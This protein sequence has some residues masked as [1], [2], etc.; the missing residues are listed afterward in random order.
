MD[1]LQGDSIILWTLS[2]GYALLQGDC[3]QGD[4]RTQKKD[5]L[6]ARLSHKLRA[7]LAGVL[8]C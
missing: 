5:V 7:L 2:H 6:F 8:P 4:F 3:F 1:S